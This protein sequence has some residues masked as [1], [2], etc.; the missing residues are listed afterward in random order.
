M[1]DISG[2]TTV[3][4]GASSGS[5]RVS[6]WRNRD[7]AAFWVGETV[8][9][10]GS[11]VTFI[12]LP[13]V[14]V[15]TLNVSTGQ[16]GALQSAEYFPYLA[17][18]LLFG[19]LA[20]R[21]RRRPLM[22]ASNAAR[23]VLIGSVPLLAILGVLQLPVLFT[24]ATATG[25]GAALFDVC[26]LSYVPGLVDR[27]RLIEAMGKVSTSHAAA[28]VV[29][30]GA[31]GLLVQL[32]TAP[33]ALVLD[34]LSYLISVVSLTM[35][36]HSEPDQGSL[37]GT[38]HIGRE[39]A[40][41][42]RFAFGEPH[43]RATAFAASMGNFF[44]FVTETIFLV[45]AVRVL[46]FSP[47]LIGLVLTAIGAGGLLGASCANIINRRFPLGR[48]YVVARLA[49]GLGAMLL[50]L[51]AGPNAAV[52][53]MCMSSFFIV[54]AALANTNVLN[55]SLRQVLTPDDIRGRMNASVRTLVYGSLSLG[56]LAVGLS[57]N[58]IGLH[59]TLWLAAIGYAA[60]IIPILASPVPR[61][62]SL[63][64]RPHPPARA[65]LGE[66]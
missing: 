35:I 21:L 16:L 9:L 18:T 36:R 63:P 1:N 2:K 17:C 55:S 34:A 39:L 60:T 41:G 62:Q 38:R 22:V 46:H 8:S 4:D 7:F 20:D 49:G 15:L 58:L 66:A 42:L 48:V 5:G 64:Q 32:V 11:Q 24:V 56:G 61:L 45:Y 43:I 50:P 3:V 12:A 28:E 19:V 37:S 30:P 52:A 47:G 23:G 65:G 26:W 44:S 59:A 53:A 33:F 27:S 57:G 54:Q 51:A 29:G 25:V 13:L 6:L 31:G 14:A 40:E 10:L